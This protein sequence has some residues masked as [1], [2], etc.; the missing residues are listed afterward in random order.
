MNA[1]VTNTRLS[2]P[3]LIFWPSLVTL[4]VTLVRLA[5]ELLHGSKTLFNAEPGGAWALVGIVW[6]VP[7][8]GIYFAL[9]LV[10][11]GD[12]PARLGRALGL[13]GL[14]AVVFAAG[15]YLYQNVIQ[16]MTDVFLMWSLAAMGASL[17]IFGWRGLF[18]VLAAYAYAARLPVAIVMLLASAR[19]WPS[20]YTA[21]EPGFSL[22]SSYVLFALIPQLVWWVS[23]T[24]IVGMLFG[25]GTAA[26]RRCTVAPSAPAASSE[27]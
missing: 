8:F 11:Q 12:H 25:I 23:F 10:R 20:H 14:G 5:G 22:L 24:I 19:N 15:F 18:R 7:I 1:T 16:N 13:A 3:R 21:A 9:R 27:S 6:L 4:A 17:Q 26:I 2:I